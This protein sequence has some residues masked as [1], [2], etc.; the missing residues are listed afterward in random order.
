ME[1]MDLAKQVSKFKNYT[2]FLHNIKNQDTDKVSQIM[3]EGVRM[4]YE[5]MQS[6]CVCLGQAE[7]LPETAENLICKFQS[8]TN[9]LLA[10]PNDIL[11]SGKTIPLTRH[12]FNMN[13][14]GENHQRTDLLDV[15]C[16][17][18]RIIPPEFI[19]G[20]YSVNEQDKINFQQNK[21]HYS[22]I[23]PQEKDRVNN[24]LLQGV[25]DAVKTVKMIMEKSADELMKMDKVYETYKKPEDRFPRSVIVAR[26]SELADIDIEAKLAKL[27]EDLG[28]ND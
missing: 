6:T 11:I 10:V 17:D 28:R 3:Q 25:P 18:K 4:N 19:Y 2:V 23:M 1:P 9:V 24:M 8:D 7:Y 22:N 26:I 15:A 16:T 14:A 27:E 12:K 13:T 5:G 21:A 20:I